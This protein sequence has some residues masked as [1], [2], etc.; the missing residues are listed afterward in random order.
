ML[1]ERRDVLAGCDRADSVILNPHKW[2]FTPVDCSALY[3]RR[4]QQIKQAFSLVPEFLRTTDPS[5]VKNLSDYGNALGRRFRALKLWMVLRYFG[6]E[7]LRARLREHLRLAR[8]LADWVEASPDFELLAP[9]PFATVVFRH[10]PPRVDPADDATLERLN[11]ALLERIN[12][13]GRAF[14]S[15]TKLRGR[16]YAL[17]A[18]IGNLRTESRH[19]E[20]LWTLLQETARALPAETGPAAGPL[21][22][23]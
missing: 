3:F 8:G 4:P 23:T 2:L 9:V 10:R 1:P 17:R 19:V 11:A 6:A 20:Q 7:G 12:A 13:S 14:L 15:H 18:A 22:R 5:E 16:Q 21:A